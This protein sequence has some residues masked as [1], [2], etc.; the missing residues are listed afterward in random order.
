MLMRTWSPS[1][2]APSLLNALHREM[3]EHSSRF[4]SNRKQGETPWF[5]MDAGDWPHTEISVD[6][7]TLVIK[8]D[9]PGIEPTEVAVTVKGN[10]LTIKGERKAEQQEQAGTSLG[11]EIRY[12]SFTRTLALPAG[13]RAE[14]VKAQYHNGVLE[15]TVPLPKAIVPKK[16]LIGTEGQ[17]PQQLEQP[18]V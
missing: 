1:R 10:Q 18:A 14:E 7:Q 9:L 12:G 8:A 17:E 3:E 13:V 15:V 16:I 2:H 11:R 6:G 4:W 5:S